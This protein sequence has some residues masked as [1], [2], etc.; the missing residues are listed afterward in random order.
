V[1]SNCSSHSCRVQQQKV[2]SGKRIVTKYKPW[3]SFEQRR[4]QDN[5]RR[6][7]WQRQL[8]RH[9]RHGQQRTIATIWAHPGIQVLLPQKQK[10]S[11]AP[12]GWVIEHWATLGPSLIMPTASFSLAAIIVTTSSDRSRRQDV[13]NLYKF[14]QQFSFQCHRLFRQ[15]DWREMMGNRVNHDAKPYFEQFLIIP[16]RRTIDFRGWSEK[17]SK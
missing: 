13:A 6:R 11:P 7:R 14:T 1:H 8:R 16:K 3:I 4:L 10:K 5:R 12:V 9:W 2:A 17:Y 15:V